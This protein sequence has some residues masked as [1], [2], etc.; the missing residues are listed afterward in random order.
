MKIIAPTLRIKILG[1][2]ILMFLLSVLI[3][4]FA[5]LNSKA[6]NN[7]DNK[8]QLIIFMLEA[9]KNEK[10]FFI[11]RDLQY[12]LKVERAIAAFDS[13]LLL[14]K[15][16]PGVKE[17]KFAMDNYAHSF[18]KV[19]TKIRERGLNENQGVEGQFRE[20]VH[21]V[22][23]MTQAAGE[24]DLLIA[25]LQARRSEKDFFLRNKPE[26]VAKVS[27]AVDSFVS[28]TSSPELKLLMYNYR[29]AFNNVVKIT[30]NVDSVKKVFNVSISKI[31]PLVD[32]MVVQEE[33]EA[34]ASQNYMLIT[35]C[36][37]L[38]L[39]IILSLVLSRS[40]TKPLIHLQN[41]AD[42]ITRG[43]YNVSFETDKQGEIGK[44]SR[45]FNSMVESIKKGI[46][47]VRH[48]SAEAEKAALASENKTNE[49]LALINN[50]KDFIWS[51]DAQYRIITANKIFVQSVK[52]EYAIDLETGLSAVDFLP[53]RVRKTFTGFYDR[54]L[55]GEQFTVE[56]CDDF[57]VT[58]VDVEVSFNP[59]VTEDNQIIGVAVFSRDISERKL[60]QE[61]IATS[62]KRLSSLINNTKDEAIIS[63]DKN[64]CLVVYNEACKNMLQR[65]T[66]KIIYEGM[67]ML[68][69]MH[70]RLRPVFKEHFDKVFA[71]ERFTEV[72]ENQR[73]KD[74]LFVELNYNPICD[75]E[76]K[77]TGI[78]I[79]ARN[80]T[81]NKL[82][83]IE[84]QKAKEKAET[85]NVAKSQFLANM[86]H[87]IR[88][89]IN[90]VIGLS[91][92]IE[93]DYEHDELLK[94]YAGMIKQSG[95]RLLNTISAILDISKI[96]SGKTQVKLSRFN[97]VSV[98][99]DNLSLLKPLA[100][101]KNIVIQFEKKTSEKMVCLDENVT[102]QILNNIIGN[103]IK[104]TNEGG[105][106]VGLSK[107]AES[108]MVVISVADTGIG[109][110]SQFIKNKLFQK[111]EQESKGNGRKYE[112]S[113]LGLSITKTL[114]EILGGSIIVNSEVGKGT[115]IIIS[116]AQNKKDELPYIQSPPKQL[117]HE[118]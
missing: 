41:A 100:E 3:V 21:L 67:N 34:K 108:G 42:S 28:R 61:I 83:E 1:L 80:I 105:I 91:E 117:L 103:A 55:M 36:A 89:P 5:V 71:G 59:I 48:K 18:E 79:F 74:M 57:T 81:E 95:Q 70:P 47:E 17:M 52:R 97:I 68:E 2:A 45:A 23:K 50:T 35:I 33:K 22:E 6:L 32:A 82:A 30:G 24:K 60:S 16:A 37:S 98:I 25:L 26:Y 78:A 14:Y 92:I 101:K 106:C 77:I 112:G 27:N 110:S 53:E 51:V 9:R 94:K 102:H 113:G 10:D 69:L 99:E 15:D 88:T 8:R 90:G 96:E 86:S 43:N 4:V 87:E 64:Y 118:Q 7:R 114:V 46:E 40:I 44:L 49:A 116:F 109:M 75:S 104:F 65:V 38:L 63:I 12:A 93:T 111:F 72:L 39:G 11:K 107:D 58:Y 54:A 84:L 20:V 66:G 73:L 19:V 62:E 29:S 31:E 56:N 85:A 13:T 76:N 115:T